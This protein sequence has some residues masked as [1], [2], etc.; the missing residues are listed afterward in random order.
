[1]K[2]RRPR[3]ARVASANRDRA[4][5]VQGLRRSS[6]AGVHVSAPRRLRTRAAE[7]AAAVLDSAS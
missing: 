2:V 3:R 5:K 7:R 4:V 1:M 6:A